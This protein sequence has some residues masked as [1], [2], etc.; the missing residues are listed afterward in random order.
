MSYAVSE[1]VAA[2]R[3]KME[4][5]GKYLHLFSGF[6]LGRRQNFYYGFRIKESCIVIIIIII[7][8][9]FIYQS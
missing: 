5:R 8:Y 1:S 3:D 7:I 2:G 9:Y 6:G 4:P